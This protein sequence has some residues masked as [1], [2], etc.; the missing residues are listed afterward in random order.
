MQPYNIEIFDTSFNLIQHYNSGVIDYKFDYLSTV[1]NSVLV[2]FKD[3]VKK[4]DYIRLVNDIDD[5]FGYTID[6]NKAKPT[7]SEFIAMVANRLK[8]DC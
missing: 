2:A 1:E 6:A 5:Y 4:G 3:N 8:L 7:N